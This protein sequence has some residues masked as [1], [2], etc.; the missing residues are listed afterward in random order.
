MQKSNVMEKPVVY[1]NEMWH[2]ETRLM[3]LFFYADGVVENSLKALDY[4]YYSH[5]YECYYMRWTDGCFEKIRA[6]LN[7]VANIS[8][9]HLHY[10]SERNQTKQSSVALAHDFSKDVVSSKPQVSMVFTL[11]KM[12]I[13]LPV[14]FEKKWMAL[15]SQQGGVFETRRQIWL[16]SRNEN[17]K[18]ILQDYFTNQGCQ[19]IM[20]E[21]RDDQIVNRLVRQTYK[22]D[23]EIHAF[24]KA[25]TLQ[26]A[27]QRTI[28]N[29][30]SQIKKLKE[31][32]SG[33]A[34]C[35]ISDDEIRDYM[36]F[37]RQELK[38]SPSSQNI[39]VS[40]IKRYLL[41]MTDRDFNPNHIP[42]PVKRKT[43][44]RV[45]DKESVAA[46]LKL[47][48]N[49]KHKCILY[50]LYSTG[51]R[52]GELLN[53]KVEDV[54]FDNNVIVV[55]QGKGEKDRIV[56]LSEKIK[57]LLLEYLKEQK[58]NIYFFEG[59]KGGKYSATSVQKI[60]KRAAHRVGIEKKTTPHVLRHSFATHL[61]DSGIDIRHIQVLLGH[62]STKT[63]EIYTHVS[64]RDIRKLK[65]PLDDLDL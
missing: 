58:P 42:R 12:Y 40:A 63:T 20:D 38:Y 6:D 1:L 60:V 16:F 18:K 57:G 53:L 24:I 13:Q 26:G 31:Y 51:M 52:C 45:I 41:A 46:I 47:D 11:D 55:K 30:A 33:K 5:Q 50:L 4:V 65:S 25:M 15:L 23:S 21:K 44:P 29:Y 49:I 43:L 17:K 3:K 22:E 27:C 59:Q 7:D 28:E 56:L 2:N 32:Y 54:S 19:I 39:V 61:H 35:D 14:P 64:K 48:L 8:T 10:P 62:T 37:L 34:V 9:K 36:F